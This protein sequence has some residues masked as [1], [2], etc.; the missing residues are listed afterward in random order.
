VL[1]VR[2]GAAVKALI[3]ALPALDVLVNCAGCIRRG[4]EHELLGFVGLSRDSRRT[5]CTNGSKDLL[6]ATSLAGSSARRAGQVRGGC[7]ATDPREV[8][9]KKRILGNVMSTKISD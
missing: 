1:D 6:E 9:F 3:A 8:P 5:L 2:G 7:Y 4:L